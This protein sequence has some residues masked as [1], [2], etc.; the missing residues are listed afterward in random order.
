MLCVITVSESTTLLSAVHTRAVTIAA[1]SITQ[2][3]ARRKNVKDATPEASTLKP[4]AAVF[5]FS[6]SRSQSDVLLKT[7]INSVCSGQMR[8][9]ACILLDEGAQTLFKTAKLDRDLDVKRTG[10]ISLHVAAFGENNDRLSRRYS[11]HLSAHR[12]EDTHI[13][14]RVDCPYNRSTY[15]WLYMI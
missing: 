1:V 15:C 10:T 8:T 6:V 9:D 5:H 11:Y 4:E 2:A 7:A 3:Y 12:T 13:H 14:Q